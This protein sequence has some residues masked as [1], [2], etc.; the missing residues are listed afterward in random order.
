MITAKSITDAKDLK[1][2]DIFDLESA[3]VDTLRKSRNK[4]EK[5][6]RQGVFH[7]SQMEA[8]GR[9]NVYEYTRAPLSDEIPEEE[10]SSLDIY[11]TGH[12]HHHVVQGVFANLR[13]ALTPIG[14]SCSFEAEKKYDEST[15]V[16]YHQLG[17]GGT[18]DGVVEIWNDVWRQRGIIEIKSANKDTFTSVCKN[19]PKRGHVEQAHLYAFRFDC[20]IM[21]IWYV[22][23]DSSK[24]KVFPITFDHDIFDSAVGKLL[25]WGEHARNGTLPPREEDFYMCPRCDYRG[26]C[27]PPS[28]AKLRKKQR[29]LAGTDLRST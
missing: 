10:L 12:V 28:L 11:S 22:H 24:R 6:E 19:G 27:N 5:A 17:L 8:C 14:L 29:S 7:P 4:E 16:L 1:R 3:Y 25:E 18:A 15:D 13:H 23:K 2:S 21:W 20:P 9:A 26:V